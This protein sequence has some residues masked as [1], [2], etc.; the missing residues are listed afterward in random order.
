MADTP[1][2]NGDVLVH[3]D[4]TRAAVRIER[5]PGE[6]MLL[7]GRALSAKILLD[8]V[9]PKCDPLGPDNKL[10]IAP[11][12]LAGTAAPTSGRLSFGA[13]S[14]LTHGI[15][16]ANS[17]GNP[18]QDLAKIGIRA[19]VIEGAPADAKARFGLAVDEAGVRLVCADAYA[20]MWN[21]ETCAKLAEAYS[22]RA[23]FIVCGPAGER[24]LAAASIACTDADNR[25]PTRHAARGGLGAVMG[26]KGL[27]FIA[28]D[29][30]KRFAAS[31]VAARRT[32]FRD[33]LK[34]QSKR[35][36]DGPQRMAKGTARAVAKAASLNTLP[37][38]N[39]TAGSP[40]AEDVKGL[41]GAT[42]L[43]SFEARG[44]GMHN[45]MVGCIVKCSNQVNRADGSYLSSALELETLGLLGSNCAIGHW[46][47]VGELDRL[48][49][50]IGLDTM[51]TGVAIG[52]LMAAGRMQWGD[53]AAMKDLIR[54]I[55]QG[56][57]LG[58][59]V[60]NGAK[61]VG[62]FT[63][64]PRVPVVKGQGL[65][66]WDPRVMKATGVTYATSA[67]GADHTAGIVTLVGLTNDAVA[68]L[69]QE[70][71]IL[72]AIGDSSGY[73]QFVQATLNEVRQFAQALFD[74]P[75]EGRELAEIG[76]QCLQAEWEFNRRAGF[77]EADDDVPG[78]MKT[79]PVGDWSY[80]FDV[81]A[82]TL[83]QVKAGMLPLSEDFYDK[84][85]F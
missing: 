78:F 32:E 75:V 9:D 70:A 44:G 19:L 24:R 42:I 60:G 74:R 38:K 3:V 62:A 14:P 18:G 65:P 63:G 12:L 71:Q 26:S 15:K 2:G 7:G 64:H 31:R 59:V 76:W 34:Q 67:M 27:K 66:V 55:A 53:V 85:I 43:A 17:G 73:C 54:Q 84:P 8:M 1:F 50:E 35:Y 20:G 52:V 29:T 81:D 4:M 25:Y 58:K 72:N 80:V 49:D 41:D 77:T 56:T 68:A 40:P 82:A 16:E 45:C 83:R 21:Y 30:G 48:C 23:S 79:E 36:F 57:E 51:E 69:S 39:R 33:L 10:I 28:I 37:Y 6:W 5:F 46:D 13:K 47:E 61:S 11:G 22:K